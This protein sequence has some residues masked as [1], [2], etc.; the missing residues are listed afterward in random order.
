MAEPGAYGEAFANGAADDDQKRAV[1]DT[2][3]NLVPSLAV[4]VPSASSARLKEVAKRAA[5]EAKAAGL[6]QKTALELKEAQ[7]KAE[8]EEFE[9]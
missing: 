4:D 9:D 3:K 1:E 2:E 5:L 8:Q 7:L 6:K